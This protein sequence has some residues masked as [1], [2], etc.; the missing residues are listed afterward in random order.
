MNHELGAPIFL[1]ESNSEIF[2]NP[3]IL[4]KIGF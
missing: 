4:Q 1:F 2:E 3:R